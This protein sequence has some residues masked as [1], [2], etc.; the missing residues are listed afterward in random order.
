MARNLAGFITKSSIAF[1]IL[2]LV[3]FACTAQKSKAELGR[4]YLIINITFGGIFLL[5]II[6]FLLFKSNGNKQRTNR[7][8]TQKNAMLQQLVADKEWLLKEVHHRVKNNLHTIVCL[9]QSQAMYLEGD[10]LKAIEISRHRIYAMTLI[11]QK[12]YQSGDTRTVEMANY[13]P[14]F[15]R[16]LR[17]SFGDPDHIRFQATIEP[18]QL[19]VSQATPIALIVNEAV[20]NAI[21]YAFPDRRPGTITILLQRLEGHM[22]LTVKDNGVGMDAVL[23]DIELNSLG[24]KLMKGLAR[25]INGAISFDIDRGT[26]ISLIFSAD[27]LLGSHTFITSSAITGAVM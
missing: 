13:L 17:D 6:L 5:L 12:I 4:S 3:C 15:I 7:M 21:K 25:E 22:K 26:R 23:L 10:A 2:S 16:Y 11:H 8:I 18:V 9:L 1:A 19:N 20:T 27:P 24:I 14:G